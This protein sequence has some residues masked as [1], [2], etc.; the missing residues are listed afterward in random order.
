MAK[1]VTYDGVTVPMVETASLRDLAAG[2]RKFKASTKEWAESE[3]LA[4][5]V[6]LSFRRAN[7]GVM[8]TIDDILDA[9]V[10][11]FVFADDEP[12]DEAPGEGGEPDPQAAGVEAG[13]DGSTSGED[14]T[15]PA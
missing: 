10:S 5:M 11:D 9:D 1:T 15:S 2:E 13:P 12:E 4:F 7:V 14:G 3:Q 8:L 6:A